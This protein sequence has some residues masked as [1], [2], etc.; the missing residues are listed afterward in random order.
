M[1]GLY[2]SFK[3]IPQFTKT[4]SYAVDHEW[5]YLEEAV[6]RYVETY[7]FDMGESD[8]QRAHVWTDL[9]QIRFV[10]YVLKGGRSGTDIYVNVRGWQGLRDVGPMQLVDGKQRLTAVLRFLRNEIPVFGGSYR[11]DFKETRFPLHCRFRW[12]VNDLKTRA[13]VL[14]WY[15][16]MN[17]G[18]T[19]HTDE[20]IE[21]VQGLL[22]AEKPG[23]KAK[24]K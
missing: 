9:Q 6:E 19:V 11:K 2:T 12:N 3:E 24:E 23:K 4:S 21:K 15:L 1:A 7:Q 13:E 5:A 18:G 22:A 20:E 17:A 14:Q 16:D 8:F 10:E